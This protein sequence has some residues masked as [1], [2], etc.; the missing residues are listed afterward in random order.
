MIPVVKRHLVNLFCEPR[1]RG[2]DPMSY[3]MGYGTAE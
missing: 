2:D 1:M 3:D